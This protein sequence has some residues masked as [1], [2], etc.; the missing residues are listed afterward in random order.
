MTILGLQF[1]NLVLNNRTS[2]HNFLGLKPENIVTANPYIQRKTKRHQSCQIDYLIQ[3]KFNTLFICEIKFSKQEIGASAISEVQ[4]K[5]KTLARPKGFSC[6]PVLI[7]VNGVSDRVLENNYF[8][9][10]LD[11]SKILTN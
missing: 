11:F 8:S 1:E 2:I 3:T 6:F 4:Q 5:I 10:I 7:Q 9:E